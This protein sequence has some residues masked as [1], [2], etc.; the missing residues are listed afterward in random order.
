MP[1]NRET[2]RI[3]PEIIGRAKAKYEA[4]ERVEDIEK[5]L[6]ISKNSVVYNAKKLGWTHGS[7]KHEIVA[8]A[9]REEESVVVADRVERSVQETEKF[10]GDTERLRALTLALNGRI[11]K[12]RDPSTNELLLDK[13]EADL[14]FQYLKCCKISMETL[15]LGYYGKRKA[16]RMDEK[17]GV[18]VHVLPWDD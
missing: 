1:R 13:E 3:P 16:L 11:F 9:A 5:D 12:S 17:E 2:H 15:S 4:G 6:G 18:E 7:R 14:I 8:R 10:I